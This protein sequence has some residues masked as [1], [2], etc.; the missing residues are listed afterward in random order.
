MVKSSRRCW[1]IIILM[2][3]ITNSFYLISKYEQELIRLIIKNKFRDIINFCSSK[4]SLT[5]A[6][7]ILENLLMNFI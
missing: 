4:F 6:S 2:V 7:L 1:Q 3:I 5:R